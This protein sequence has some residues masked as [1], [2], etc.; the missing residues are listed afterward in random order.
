MLIQDLNSD[1]EA[2]PSDIAR[3]LISDEIVQLLQHD[4]ITYLI[5]G[6]MKSLYEIPPDDVIPA[7]QAEIQLE[8][9]DSVS[10]PNVNMEQ[11]REVLGIMIKLDSEPD[12]SASWA[13]IHQ[14]LT[15]DSLSKTW[16]SPCILTL[17]KCAAGHVALLDEN[18][19][20]MT[21]EA[22]KT[23]QSWRRSWVSHLEGIRHVQRPFPNECQMLR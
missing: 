1:P 7:A 4:I 12:Q 8:L 11:T 9:A 3:R 16:L 14:N 6:G 10:F 19:E 2:G 20:T 21:R 5:P 15:F 13:S 17:E 18:R 22:R 23:H